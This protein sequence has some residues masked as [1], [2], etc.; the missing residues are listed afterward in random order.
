MFVSNE[1]VSTYIQD[2]IAKDWDFHKAASGCQTFDFFM[3][4]IRL[5]IYWVSKNLEVVFVSSK[6]H[7]F[8]C[9]RG[10][11]PQALNWEFSFIKDF[12][13]PSGKGPNFSLKSIHSIT[14]HCPHARIY[15]L[16]CLQAGT[17]SS[18][19]LFV[20]GKMLLLFLSD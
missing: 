12:G 18:L 16:Q 19:S 6:S 8:V 3:G 5:K 13:L 9:S 15:Q 2:R 20:L 7:P 17:I 14:H 11:I 4:L 10:C 1:F